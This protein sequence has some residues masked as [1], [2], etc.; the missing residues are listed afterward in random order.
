MKV[1]AV[2]IVESVFQLLKLLLTAYNSYWQPLTAHKAVDSYCCQNKPHLSVHMICRSKSLHLQLAN[3]SRGINWGAIFSAVSWSKS[4]PITVL[5]SCNILECDSKVFFAQIYFF[6]IVFVIAST[7]WGLLTVFAQI[8]KKWISRQ[9][10]SSFLWPF[11]SA[12]WSVPPK[13]SKQWWW[14]CCTK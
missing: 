14:Q 3:S 4:L 11:M 2:K 7:Q 8:D 9:C 5:G 10:I 13:R 12:L 6:V 1:S